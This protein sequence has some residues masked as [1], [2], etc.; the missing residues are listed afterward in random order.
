MIERARSYLIRILRWSEKFTK[1]DMVY[2]ASGGFW[3]VFEQ[4]MAAIFAF[5]LAVAFGHFASKDLYGNYKYVLSLAS[6]L[7]AF[8]L[9][10]IGTAVT[11]AAARGKE[12]TLKQGF[13][14][15]LRWSV[16]MSL[17]SLGV[18]G[19]YFFQ[20]N[21]F[22][23]LSM[24]VVALFSPFL[25]SFS[26]FDNFLIGLRKFDR[27]ALYSVVIN[28][29]SMI[30]LI[31]ALFAGHRAIVLVIAYFAIKHDNSCPLLYSHATAS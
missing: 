12:G 1:T 18:G 5:A 28:F 17:I 3:L 7:T 27:V 29:A 6:V 26:L 15:N 23:A 20:G 31:L 22:V 21:S 25:Y 14:I 9:S 30:I 16:P 11:Q 2:L 8:S 4:I 24:W 19:F 10:G 13:T